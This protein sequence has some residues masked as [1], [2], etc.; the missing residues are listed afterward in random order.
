MQS[1]LLLQQSLV[2]P[3]NSSSLIT[4][5][6]YCCQFSLRLT[7]H[8]IAT[9]LQEKIQFSS[10]FVLHYHVNSLNRFVCC[11]SFFFIKK[12][13]VKAF[14]CALRHPQREILC[15]HP[16]EEVTQGP[17][18]NDVFLYDNDSSFKSLQ[19]VRHGYPHASTHINHIF[20]ACWHYAKWCCIICFFFSAVSFNWSPSFSSENPTSHPFTCYSTARLTWLSRRR[21]YWTSLAIKMLYTYWFQVAPNACAALFRQSSC[22][23]EAVGAM[24]MF[25]CSHLSMLATSSLHSCIFVLALWVCVPTKLQIRSLRALNL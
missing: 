8:D 2:F 4:A 18:D 10:M 11:L 17:S 23:G 22:A 14:T 20:S 5:A 3:P 9:C 1:L 24:L 19:K 6:V 21:P 25:F 16:S 12:T 13:R 15:F 7:R